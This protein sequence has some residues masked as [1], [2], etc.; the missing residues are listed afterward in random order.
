MNDFGCL[1]SGVKKGKVIFLE[2]YGIFLH[3]VKHTLKM[4]WT[5]AFKML[6]DLKTLN[7]QKKKNKELL[8]YPVMEM[9][10]FY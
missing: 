1:S 3:Y 8:D 2:S 9:Q 7:T 10:K 5:E 4:F 6:F